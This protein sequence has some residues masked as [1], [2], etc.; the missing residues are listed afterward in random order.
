ML[1]VINTNHTATI[2]AEL[3]NGE[4]IV[5]QCEI[6]HPAVATK[7]S[8]SSGRTSASHTG[9]ATPAESVIFDPI[10]R[11]RH[12]QQQQRPSGSSRLTVGAFGDGLEPSGDEDE[13][14]D[15]EEGEGE[16][17]DDRSEAAGTDD[18]DDDDV[19][20][21]VQRVSRRHGKRRPRRRSEN[22][23]RQLRNI[24][25]SKTDGGSDEDGTPPLSAPIERVFYVNAYRNEV[26]PAPNPAFLS[27]LSNDATTLVYSCGSLWTSLVPCLALRGVARAIKS[28]PSLRYKVL[29][30]NTTHDR[31]T[32]GLDAVDFIDVIYRALLLYPRHRDQGYEPRDFVTHVVYFK[33][34]SVKVDESKL[35][36][37]GIQCI[38]ATSTQSASRP[39]FDEESVK[40]ALSEIVTSS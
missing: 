20:D 35:Q 8:A 28:S 21:Y 3:A 22:E 40:R 11:I 15:D 14:S 26:H 2:A 29:L 27:C 30:L 18:D 23:S 25:F 31:E 10:Q 7:T 32:A 24:V 6:S 33:N 12:Q 13:Q 36:S 38:C 34:G 4:T 37:M 16:I 17:D 1:P 5:G 19:V 39:R 9:P